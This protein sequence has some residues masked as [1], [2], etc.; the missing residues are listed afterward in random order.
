MAQAGSEDFILSSSLKG[1][2]VSGLLHHL[3]PL[4]S[5]S[6]FPFAVCCIQ[7]HRTWGPW[8]LC[9]IPLL[10]QTYPASPHLG[11]PL[12]ELPSLHVCPV[13]QPESKS[14][15]RFWEVSPNLS[16]SIAMAQPAQDWIIYTM[17]LNLPTGVWSSSEILQRV[18]TQTH[19]HTQL[20]IFKSAC[21]RNH[22]NKGSW[23]ITALGM[24]CHIRFSLMNSIY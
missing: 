14:E 3:I 1:A 18:S 5:V 17:P 4:V 15:R 8:F 9:L 21:C 22:S 7:A 10:S 11:V 6:A 24:L 19:P 16:H 12:A 2:G 20:L 23:L 13:S